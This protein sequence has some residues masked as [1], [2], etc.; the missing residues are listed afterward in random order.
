MEKCV[1]DCTGAPFP[2]NCN[3]VAPLFGRYMP[4]GDPGGFC[5]GRNSTTFFF[6]VKC[7]KPSQ[8][9]TYALSLTVPDYDVIDDVQHSYTNMLNDW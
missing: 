1:S 9:I 8:H 5:P 6:L 3:I 2:L 4:N 7:E